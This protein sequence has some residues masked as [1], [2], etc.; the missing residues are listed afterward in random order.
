MRAAPWRRN[1]R[2]SGV[3]PLALS[4]SSK[5]QGRGDRKADYGVPSAVAVP[6]KSAGLRVAAPAPT[7]I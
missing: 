6:V 5:A 1:R 3:T 2:A 4:I 7:L